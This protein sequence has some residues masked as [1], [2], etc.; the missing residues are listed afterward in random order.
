MGLK[1]DFEK[2]TKETIIKAG[3]Q[4]L[5][6]NPE[7]NIDKLYSLIK[8][9]MKGEFAEDKFDYVYE[10]YKNNE[11]TN[12]FIQDIFKNTHK[13][14]LT[15]FF[16]NFIGNE[17]WYGISKREKIGQENDTKIPFTILLSPSMRCNLRCTGCY[18]ANYSKKDDLPF[19]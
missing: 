3:V 14:C 19:E 1:D 12:L 15:K 7:K 18:A 17:N 9:G 16:T 10:Y 6:K 2:K 8:K 11:A 13:N 5:E 4:L